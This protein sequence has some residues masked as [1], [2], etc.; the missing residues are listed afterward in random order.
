MKVGKTDKS[1]TF[2]AMPPYT[3]SKHEITK[4]KKQK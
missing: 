2:E 3:K 4:T 1:L